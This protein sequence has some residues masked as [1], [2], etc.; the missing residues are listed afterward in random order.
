MKAWFESLQPR[1]RIFVLSA[2]AVIALAILYLGI[3]RP[4]DK[5]HS[6]MQASVQ[7]W[8]SALSELRP[9]QEQLQSASLSGAQASRN[10]S[11][12]VIIDNSL[13]Q[14]GLYGAL[15]RSQPTAQNGIRVEFENA[16]F[17]DLILWL[18]DLATAH[19]LQLQSGSFSSMAADNA[20]R[21][22]ATVTLER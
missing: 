7:T 12:V 20:G 8:G 2:T 17:D 22:N 16:S 19:G 13:R 5:A 11:L 4:L 6:A 3:W 9:L 1:E 21:V 18:G 14:R 15:Q 10:E